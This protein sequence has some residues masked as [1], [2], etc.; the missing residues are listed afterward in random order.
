LRELP[1]PAKGLLAAALKPGS[2]PAHVRSYFALQGDQQAAI[3]HAVNVCFSADVPLCFETADAS[4]CGIELNAGGQKLAWTI[5]EYL[6]DL[7][8]E[9]AALLIPP[10]RTAATSKEAAAKHTGVKQADREQSA[11][12]PAYR[13]DAVAP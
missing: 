3:R 1:G 5:N 13:V 12:P 9:V 7:E 4:V 11:G 6:G 10:A 8:Y 2:E